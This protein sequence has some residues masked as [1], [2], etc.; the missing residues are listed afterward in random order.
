MTLELR[1]V[2]KPL[3]TF[4]TSNFFSPLGEEVHGFF[5]ITGQTELFTTFLTF[6]LVFVSMLALPVLCLF[7]P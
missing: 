1:W 2:H 3:A 5:I 6:I 4:F 7:F